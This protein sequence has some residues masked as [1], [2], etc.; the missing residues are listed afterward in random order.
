T[1]AVRSRP[2]D[3]QVASASSA[4]RRRRKFS[5]RLT[6]L[7]LILSLLTISGAATNAIWFVRSRDTSEILN[8]RF[9]ALSARLAARRTSELL[10]PAVY[11]LREYQIEAQR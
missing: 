1:R 8:D 2:V 5:L 11:A 10:R 3:T 9:F 7:A 6:L 4:A